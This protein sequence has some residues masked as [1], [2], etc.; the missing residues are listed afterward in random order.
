MSRY[1]CGCPCVTPNGVI[2][3]C[4]WGINLI[5]SDKTKS[6]SFL[7]GSVSIN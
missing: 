7:K 3:V 1:K 4:I 5:T 6:P 2:F